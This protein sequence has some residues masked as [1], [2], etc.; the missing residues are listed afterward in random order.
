MVFS[1]LYF[2]AV[3]KL[4]FLA[5]F[6]EFLYVSFY[7]SAVER[8]NSIVPGVD[9][10]PICNDMRRKILDE[11]TFIFQV[12]SDLAEEG[13]FDHLSSIDADAIAYPSDGGYQKP[14]ANHQCDDQGFR[15][16]LAPIQERESADGQKYSEVTGKNQE[17][18][19]DRRI[20]Q[21]F[22]ILAHPPNGAR[23]DDE[24]VRHAEERPQDDIQNG[25]SVHVVTTHKRPGRQLMHSRC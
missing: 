24:G 5:V 18:E 3:F 11:S 4:Y 10:Y 20:V 6:K 16:G 25:F 17:S 1:I 14:W 19:A 12:D 2:L 13:L 7:P 23:R 21:P 8:Y 15:P 22:A 9:L